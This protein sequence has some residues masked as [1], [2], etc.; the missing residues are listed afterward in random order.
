MK[1]KKVTIREVA[2]LAGVSISSVSRYLADP[3][4]IQPLAAYN[5]KNAINELQYE[6]NMFARNLKR[7]QTQIVGLI[8]PHMEYFFGKI[9]HVVSDYFF[10]RKYITYIC[11]SDS[12]R[13]KELFYVQELLNQRAAGIIIA[14]SGQNTPYLQGVTKNYKNM[15]AIDRQEDIGCDMVL[16]NHRDNAYHLISWLLKNK[17]CSR[18]MMLFGWSDSFNTRM[19]L[20]GANQALEEAGRDGSRVIKIFT[21]R[22]IEVVMDALSD[23]LR[24]D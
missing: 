11:E 7:G 8:V 4:S 2:E 21:A 18:I 12:E 23:G 1:E 9:C 20:A 6:P 22:K 13:E 24:I 3:K 19:C 15:I 5:I 10:E 17:P 16:E 14:P